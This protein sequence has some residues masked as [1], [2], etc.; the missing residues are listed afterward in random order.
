[1]AVRVLF[2]DRSWYSA[3]RYRAGDCHNVATTKRGLDDDTFSA[4]QNF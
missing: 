3:D 2:V 4:D 1:V